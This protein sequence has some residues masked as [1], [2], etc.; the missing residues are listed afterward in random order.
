MV[1]AEAEIR[2]MLEGA[3]EHPDDQYLRG[4]LK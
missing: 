4:A 2:E 1:M 3:A